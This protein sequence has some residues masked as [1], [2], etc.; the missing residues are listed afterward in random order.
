MGIRGPSMFIASLPNVV[1][2]WVFWSISIFPERYPLASTL[3]SPAPTTFCNLSF[4]ISGSL[5]SSSHWSSKTLT[6]PSTL[7][8]CYKYFSEQLC[9]RHYDRDKYTWARQFLPSGVQ[10]KKGGLRCNSVRPN[11][12]RQM[13]LREAQ[14][15]MGV[16]RRERTQELHPLS[17]RKK[18]DEGN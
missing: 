16:Q 18:I 5:F 17:I 9:A 8:Q 4:L 10:S 7:R 12:A 13:P 6:Q 11:R 1:S 15:S 3:T 14:N 2:S